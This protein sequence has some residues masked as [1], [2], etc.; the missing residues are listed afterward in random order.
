L[1]L[2][3]LHL[4]HIVFV[5]R[6][7]LR[8]HGL[9]ALCLLAWGVQARLPGFREPKVGL[10]L[11]LRRRRKVAVRVKGCPRGSLH[12]EVRILVGVLTVPRL[13]ELVFDPVRRQ[14]VHVP[15]SANDPRIVGARLSVAAARSGGVARPA[16]FA[17]Q[18]HLP[19]VMLLTSGH[20][21]KEAV[22]GLR[23]RVGAVFRDRRQEPGPFVR[24][25]RHQRSGA[26][27]AGVAPL[28]SWVVRPTDGMHLRVHARGPGP[29]H[30]ASVVAVR[31]WQPFHGFANALGVKRT[32]DGVER[33]VAVQL[34]EPRSSPSSIRSAA[35]LQERF[36]RQP[37]GIG[38]D[39]W[40]LAA[41]KATF[42]H[43]GVRALVGPHILR[44]AR[45]AVMVM[46]RRYFL[47]VRS[48]YGGSANG[49]K[50]TKVMQRQRLSI[51]FLN[52][53]QGL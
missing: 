5:R 12:V 9:Q 15:K 11:G 44:R 50:M 31:A 18:G 28:L 22:V 21:A 46:L 42:E 34:G 30:K 13:A 48:R 35:V 20:R 17:H 24:P 33:I 32:A 41:R 37:R 10:L 53:F 14:P 19:C 27:E 47:H 6:L 1:L 2:L 4:V 38:P 40:L 51:L 8:G 23:K 49:K 29:A 45:P 36:A 16:S 3:L 43:G 39:V 52:V 7:L 26:V 25:K